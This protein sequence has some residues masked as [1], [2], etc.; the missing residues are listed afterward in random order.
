MS[1]P[2]RRPSVRPVQY[3]GAPLDAERGPGL[4]CFWVQ[5]A[6]LAVLVV[7][8]PLT[9]GR[10]PWE[11]SAILLFAIIA[12]LLLVGQTVIFLLRLVAADRRAAR[13]PGRPIAERS[14]TVGELEAA[15]HEAADGGRELE[16]A[17]TGSAAHEAGGDAT[18]GATG[19]NEVSAGRSGP[20]REGDAPGGR[21]SVR[22]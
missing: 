13:R 20:D 5:I 8:T 4:G 1:E 19:P 17:E 2:E 12:L 11:V 14:P 6:V 15:G 22:E 21:P 7:A 18:P 16:P 3:K 10:V 9:V